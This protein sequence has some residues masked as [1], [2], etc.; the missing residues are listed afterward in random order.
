MYVKIVERIPDT[1]QFVH[2]WTK[3]L[4][5]P[6]E[7]EQGEIIMFVRH[8]V[9]DGKRK[10]QRLTRIQGF[11]Y[12]GLTVSAFCTPRIADDFF[13]YVDIGQAGKAYEI[14]FMN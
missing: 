13:Q 7:T 1:A 11:S 6:L 2:I 9:T 5:D 14:L 12:D 8:D 4:P 3:E 10:I